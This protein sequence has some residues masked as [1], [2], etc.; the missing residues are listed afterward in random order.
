MAIALRTRRLLL[1]E[2]RDEDVESFA[3]MS[4]DPAMTEF[5][6]PYADRLAIEAWVERAR[7]RWADHGFGLFVVELPGEAPFVGVVG[8]NDLHPAAPAAPA[9]EGAWRIARPYW[10]NG[11]A[12]EAARAVFE[13]GFF[14]LGLHEIV[15]IAMERNQRSRRVMETVG[16]TRDPAE[17]FDFNHPAL[18]PNHPLRR[19]VLY[20]QRRPG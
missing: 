1:R 9:I 11:Y 12:G 5:L 14:R 4:A 6:L 8:L 16:M 20:R 19:H 18:G 10:G 17:D 3:V 13:D 2:W 7:R 15:A